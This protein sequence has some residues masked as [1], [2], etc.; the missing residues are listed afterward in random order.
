MSD[1]IPTSN[2]PK[3][4]TDEQTALPGPLRC[5]VGSVLSGAIAYLLYLLTLSIAQTFASKPIH[6]DQALTIS[7]ATAVRTLVVGATALGA[8]IF[9][10]TAFGLLALTVQTVMQ[11]LTRKSTPNA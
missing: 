7:I 10:I 5:L 4:T 3:T 11:Q 6:A 9:G 2:A 1:P 8:G